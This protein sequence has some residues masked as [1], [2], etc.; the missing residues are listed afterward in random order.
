V[1]YNISPLEII[2][3]ENLFHIFPQHPKKE[4]KRKRINISLLEIIKLENLFHIIP[5]HP[6]EKKE[7]KERKSLC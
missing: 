2:K 6:R 4:K 5:Q 7:R 3:L 1:V